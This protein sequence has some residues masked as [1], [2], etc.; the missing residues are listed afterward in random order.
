MR[1]RAVQY[2]LSPNAE[3]NIKL[4]PAFITM[5]LTIPLILFLIWT[6]SSLFSEARF[7][8][9]NSSTTNALV[10]DKDIKTRVNFWGQQE[11]V[12]RVYLAFNTTG[13]STYASYY[14]TSEADFQNTPYGAVEKV[15]YSN[16]S[17]DINGR[18]SDLLAA[19]SP[20][21]II[22]K[23]ALPAI[24][25]ALGMILLFYYPSKYFIRKYILLK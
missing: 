16:L 14:D 8:L 23:I 17:A 7:I 4:F 19:A 25:I 2:S 3:K 18:H 11:A 10:I 21:S 6:Q 12:Y 9:S 5:T 15:T 20:F 1:N 22:Q 13:I 24:V